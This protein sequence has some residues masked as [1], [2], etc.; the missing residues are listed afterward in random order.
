MIRR[1][2]WPRLWLQGLAVLLFIALAAA[3]VKQ[4]SAITLGQQDNFEIVGMQDGLDNWR[5]GSG[6]DPS[7]V[8]I[9]TGGP[10]GS[11]D[12]YLQ[13]S[14]GTFDN[15]FYRPKLVTFNT[16][17]WIGDYLT[18]AIGAIAV[19]LQN[20]SPADPNT[21]T[22]SMRVAFWQ[23]FS[24]GYATKAYP[25][26]NDGQW[27]RVYFSLAQ[28]QMTADGA[29]DSYANLLSAVNGELAQLRIL[30]AQQP[31]TSG[32]SGNF[33]VGID[34]VTAVP[35]GDFDLNGA[36][37]SADLQTLLQA[38]TNIPAYKA[39]HNLSDAD[40][41]AFGDVNR[42]GVF[43]NADIQALLHLLATNASPGAPVPE[44][45]AAALVVGAAVCL[46][47]YCVRRRAKLIP[48]R[49]RRDARRYISLRVEDRHG[50][51]GFDR[52]N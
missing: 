39:A 1:S 8:N 38:L 47:L 20:F 41:L 7:I 31:V 27:H 3:C 28:S 48:V 13:V 44:P 17:Q 32:D 2:S 22:L 25:L 52:R 5:N 14:S 43:D 4:A 9:A 15:Q 37:N 26:V 24:T 50:C 35:L 11:G 46:A 45:P 21:S 16:S 42:D 51:R 10:A 40:L 30:N 6:T 29:P 33:R 49:I 23:G 34:N 19:D 12:H 18:P 36:R